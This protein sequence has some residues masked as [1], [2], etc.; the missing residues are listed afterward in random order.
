[1]SEDNDQ[2]WVSSYKK[3]K[4]AFWNKKLKRKTIDKIR[5][6]A[7]KAAGLE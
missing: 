1:M 3:L 7:R 4:K 6:A 5:R 2:P